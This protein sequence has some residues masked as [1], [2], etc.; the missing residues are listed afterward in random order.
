MLQQPGVMTQTCAPSPRT[1][2]RSPQTI[3][4]SSYNKQ[5]QNECPKLKMGR[6]VRKEGKLLLHLGTFK[7]TQD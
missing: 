6:K 5:T 3:T 1:A 7:K 2:L 4:L